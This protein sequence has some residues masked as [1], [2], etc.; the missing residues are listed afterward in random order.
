MA[1]AQLEAFGLYRA[2]LLSS[3]SLNHEKITGVTIKTCTSELT[4]PP[5]TGVASGFMTSAPVRVD[6]IMGKRPATTVA[7]V[8]TLGRK[9]SNAPSTTASLKVS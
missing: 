6:H 9:R 7:T 8:M 3:R 4:M 5:S 2:F 1:K